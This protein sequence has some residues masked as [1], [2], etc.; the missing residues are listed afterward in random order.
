MSTQPTVSI[1][2]PVYNR[3]ALLTRALLSVE[4]QTF[5]S[6]ECLIVDDGSTDNTADVAL[7][8]V[9][10]DSRFKFI[11]ITHSGGAKATNHGV[12][13]ATGTYITLLGSDDEYA[14]EHIRLRVEELEKN[15]TLDVLHGGITVIGNEMVPDKRDVTKEISLYNPIVYIGGTIF[16]K[17]EV[18]YTLNGFK[19]MEYASDSDFV[20]RAIAVF[21][22]KRV[23][24]P[25]YLYYRD[26][27]DSATFRISQEAKMMTSQLPQ[28]VKRPTA[29]ST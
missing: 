13:T 22:V 21:N 15:T 28:F 2:I 27:A 20:E 12:F 24:W 14:P 25:T 29:S 6:W 26:H 19:K 5:F 11:Q 3:P 4:K 17:S 10:K 23:M 1:V 8:F 18:F 7:D 16:A 9:N